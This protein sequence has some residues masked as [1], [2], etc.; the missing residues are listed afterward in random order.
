MT[1][2]FILNDSPYGTQRTYNALRL[3][4][5]ISAAGTSVR[6]FLLGDGVTAAL[7]GLNPA[8]ADYNP[9]EMLTV[10]AQRGALIRVCRT[11]MDM[12]GI[13]DSAL[14]SGA[15]RS[16]MDELVAWTEECDK[17]LAF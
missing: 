8:H 1:Y 3:A 14:I 5:A 17:V 4:T 12:R 2:L 16:T 9:Q 11:C 6:V 13:P 15:T 7:N 10:L